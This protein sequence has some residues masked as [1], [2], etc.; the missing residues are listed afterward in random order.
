MV[1]L[2][3]GSIL[4][5]GNTLLPT[6]HSV[7]FRYQQKTN[8][9]QATQ[10]LPD[11]VVGLG[12]TLTKLPNGSVLT[13]GTAHKKV[14]AFVF[15]LDSM[16]WSAT[17]ALPSDFISLD[18]TAVALSSGEVLI[19]GSEGKQNV[20]WLYKYK[21]NSWSRT[22]PPPLKTTGTD[23]ATEIGNGS[24]LVISR[25]DSPTQNWVGLLYKP[26]T[27]SWTLTGEIPTTMR[28]QPN[29][30]VKLSDGTVLLIGFQ[31]YPTAETVSILYNP[32]DNKWTKVGV[33]PQPSEIHGASLL[34]KEGVVLVTAKNLLTN[35]ISTLLY[36]P[37]KREWHF[38]SSPPV[39][40]TYIRLMWTFPDGTLFAL[41]I[42]NHSQSDEL[43][44]S[45]KLDV[46]TKIGSLPDGAGH[47]QVLSGNDS[48]VLFVTS[49]NVDFR[50]AISGALVYIP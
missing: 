49:P 35:A 30:T 33:L 18:R 16:S 29:S 44:Y 24:V 7:A 45:P 15:N 5:V 48:A 13:L 1:T 38:A 19:M 17:G 37:T 43:S 42:K 47:S 46:W 21:T 10:A 23:Y 8:E 25:D 11:D 28:S 2:D 14:V 32:T 4:G 6:P 20:G 39:G 41:G 27:D 12:A 34:S 9:W 31:Q 26:A 22:Q 50:S 36:N 3:D 40:Y